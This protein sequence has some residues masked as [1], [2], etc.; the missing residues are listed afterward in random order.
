[1]ENGNLGLTDAIGYML[2]KF[3]GASIDHI[4]KVNFNKTA[5]FKLASRVRML[6]RDSITSLNG[7]YNALKERDRRKKLES[8]IAYYKASMDF[9]VK[10]RDT[11]RVFI[12]FFRYIANVLQEGGIDRLEKLIYLTKQYE[13]DNVT[14]G[15]DKITISTVHSSKGMEWK[16][17]ILMAYDNIC[18]PSF[19]YISELSN[20]NG[21]TE[22]DIAEYIDGERRLNYVALTRAKEKI[23]VVT[24][25]EPEELNVESSKNAGPKIFKNYLRYVRAISNGNTT[26]AKIILQSSA[27][28]PNTPPKNNVLNNLEQ[29]IK[30]ELEKLGYKVETNIGNADYKISLGI[31]D[32]KLDKYLIGVECDYTAFK[33]SPSILERDVFRPTFLKSRG[34]DIL[35]VWSRDWWLHKT[36]IVNL[37]V[38]L[39]EK[40]RA[41]FTAE[42]EKPEKVTAP[43]GTRNRVITIKPKTTTKKK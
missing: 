24:S 20:R 25:I 40:N 23:Y 31:Y 18:F 12:C 33:S 30:V 19:K 38:K 4:P 15:G 1:M 36:K 43:N 7:V 6:N 14:I 16:H 29:Q 2:N 35:R 8:L 42:Q 34:W 39:A 17:V 28:L 21:V 13:N 5:E 10:D 37:I 41:K 11:R 3:F 27:T 22:N 32:K 26:E 9:T